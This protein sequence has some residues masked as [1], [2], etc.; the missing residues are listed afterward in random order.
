MRRCV[1]I[2]GFLVALIAASWAYAA[3]PPTLPITASAHA[4]ALFKC[5]H[6][7]VSTVDIEAC[8]GHSL[9][10]LDRQFNQKVAIIWPLLDPIGK[11]G[12]ISGQA[13]WLT[14]RNQECTAAARAY[15]GGTASPVE[16][17]SCEVQLTTARV[18]DLSAL[19]AVYCQGRVRSGPARLCPRA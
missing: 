4:V 16:Y 6:N 9:L 3:G 15:L 14:Y 17:G 18:R 1:C 5:P 8:E 12:L 2:T 11:Q 19:V 13:A 7:P 10:A